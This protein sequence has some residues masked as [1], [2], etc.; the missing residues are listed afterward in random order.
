MNERIV[1]GICGASGVIYGIRLLR[2]LLSGP[3]EIHLIISRAGALVLSY[4]LGFK[5]GLAFEELL[6]QNDV[7]LHKDARLI[8]H[9]PDN[10]M[11]APASGSFRHSGMVIVP[12]SMKTLGAIASGLAT[13][14]I[15]RAAD[16]CLKEKRPLVLVP[17]ETP[18]NKI[19]IKNMLLAHEAGATILPP[20]P[21]FYFRPVSIYDLVDFVV[22]RVLD[23]LHIKHDLV[24]EWNGSD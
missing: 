14:L 12:C 1:I 15:A 11:A 8:I 17:R 7:L 2:A 9:E 19:H 6:K 18:L 10:L 23:Q 5:N 4:E 20:A 24:G 13:T 16:V 3:R 22:G 21:A